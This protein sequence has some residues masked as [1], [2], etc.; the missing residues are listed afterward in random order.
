MI[1]ANRISSWCLRVL[2]VKRIYHQDTKTP[3]SLSMRGER[4]QV[5]FAITCVMLWLFVFVATGAT[6]QDWERIYKEAESSIATG[7]IEKAAGLLRK[8]LVASPADVRAHNL[9]G[10]ALT[11]GG[12]LDEGNLHFRKAIELNPNFHAALKNLALNELKQNRLHDARVHFEEFLKQVPGDP[13]AHMSLGE[14]HFANR[15]FKLAMRH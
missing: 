12:K 11:A 6:Q 10:I 2:V 9:L 14:I 8:I 5:V 1:T 3:R 15:Q 7:E 13:V 4:V